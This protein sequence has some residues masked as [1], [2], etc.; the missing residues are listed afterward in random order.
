MDFLQSDQ[1]TRLTITPLNTYITVY[2]QDRT[3]PEKKKK[4]E[5]E[6]ETGD[7]EAEEADSTYG[8]IGT[9]TQLDTT[10]N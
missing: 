5:D 8:G 6:G 10:R 2:Q 1:L 4:A 7:R 3:S 9:F